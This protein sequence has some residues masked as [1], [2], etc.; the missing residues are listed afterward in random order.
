M[1]DFDT[2]RRSRHLTEDERTFTLGG[3][4]FLVKTGVRPEALA[5]FDSIES[6]SGIEET[7]AASD[8]VILA[9]LDPGDDAHTRFMAIRADDEDPLTAE[10][11]EEIV[12]WMV[13]LVTGRPPTLPTAS[14]EEPSPT[15][16][17]LTEDSSS[18]GLRA[19]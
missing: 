10:D 1:R 14:T 4:K 7:M 16:M 8:S 15:G 5:V 13:E 2:S 3:Q 9:M 18:Q 17:T 12:Q 11:L 6:T 19:V